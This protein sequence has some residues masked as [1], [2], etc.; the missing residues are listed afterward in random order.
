MTTKD[1]INFLEKKKIEYK[2]YKHK[3]V[4][5]ADKIAKAC[6]VPEKSVIKGL[7]LK[8]TGGKFILALLPANMAVKITKIKKTL[9]LKKLEIANEKEMKAKTGFKPGAAPFLGKMLKVLVVT[10]KLLQKTK[11]LVFPGGDYKTS[12][13]VNSLDWFKLEQPEVL[14]FSVKPSGK[15]KTKKKK[16]VKKA[17][18]KKIAKKKVLKKKV[19]KKVAIKKTE[20]TKIVKNKKIVKKKSQK[21]VVKKVIKKI[22]KKNIKK[23][24]KK[25]GKK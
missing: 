23:Q 1:I 4:Y 12:I 5:T 9:E 2:L 22:N 8:G 18:A 19:A 16:V 20:K 21:K 24:V 13:E 10:D 17:V 3:E 11:S 6:K 15:K 25:G 7:F 14:D